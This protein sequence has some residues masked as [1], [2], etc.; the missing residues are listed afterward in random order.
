MTVVAI[1]LTFASGASDVA[2]FT[3]LGN[4]FTSVMTGNITLFGLSLARGSTSLAAHTAVAFA[5]YVT[6]VIICTRIAWYRTERRSAGPAVKPP[7]GSWPP[8]MT[9][10]LLTELTLLLGVLAG[11]ELT[12]TRPAGGAQFV[13][14]VVAACAMG[15]QSAAVNQMGLGNVST[16]FLTGTLTGLVS[17]IARPGSEADAR[18]TGVLAGLVTGAVLAGVLDAAAA[19]LVPLLPLFGVAAAVALGSGRLRPGWL[20]PSPPA[21]PTAPA[22][23]TI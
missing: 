20:D 14:L 6:G 2:S 13:I 18:R 11:W 1:V 21:D 23:P 5:G 15:I 12:G 9:L 3:R 8:H 19:A 16:T 22:S 7:G 10:T 17:A 4:V